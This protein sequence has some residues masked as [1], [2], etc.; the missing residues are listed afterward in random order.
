MTLTRKNTITS[1]SQASAVDSCALMSHAHSGFLPIHTFLQGSPYSV[2]LG[3]ASQNGCAEIAEKLLIKGADPNY[4][5]EVLVYMCALYACSLNNLCHKE[6]AGVLLV[7]LGLLGA[8]PWVCTTPVSICLHIKF[9]LDTEW[10]C[11]TPFCYSEA[12]CE[13]GSNFVEVWSRSQRESQSSGTGMCVI[14]CGVCVGGEGKEREESMP[15]IDLDL[16]STCGQNL[17][18]CPF[19]AWSITIDAV[20]KAT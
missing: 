10:Q 12:S 6:V 16:H 19:I 15:H 20:S 13:S 3:V 7:E 8:S 4:Q 1:E 2:P 5:D 17:L 9:C 14:T 11:T 18:P